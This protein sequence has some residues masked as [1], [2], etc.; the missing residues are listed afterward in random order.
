MNDSELLKHSLDCF[1]IYPDCPQGLRWKKKITRIVRVGKPAGYLGANGY[2]STS[3]FGHRIYN[4]RVIF[5]MV[6]GY[7]PDFIDHIDGNRANNTVSNLRAATKQ[8]NAWNKGIRS[9][10]KS[11][12]AGVYWDA[13]AKKWRSEVREGDQRLRK[14]FTNLEEAVAWRREQSLRH[15]GAYSPQACR[16]TEGGQHAC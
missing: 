4:H 11:G 3:L 12:H 1:E 15:Y 6:N 7:L 5:L 8:Q 9:D 13:W 16:T 14:R 10:N 2:Y